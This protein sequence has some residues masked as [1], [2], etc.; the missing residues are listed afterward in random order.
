MAD[1]YENQAFFVKEW[2]NVLNRA[3]KGL[4]ERAAA[5]ALTNSNSVQMLKSG[6]DP[7]RIAALGSLWDKDK[8]ELGDMWRKQSAFL[9]GLAIRS[10]DNNQ[11]K[12]DDPEEEDIRY[13]NAKGV[14]TDINGAARPQSR[15]V[16]ASYFA[17][18]LESY[19]GAVALR[20]RVLGSGK[21]TY[22][23]RI[24]L[25]TC[26]K[27][28]PHVGDLKQ[29]EIEPASPPSMPNSVKLLQKTFFEQLTASQSLSD[30]GEQK[31]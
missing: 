5:A 23:E 26:F 7:A 12:L 3:R 13:R 22:S 10:F 9:V 31:W 28:P 16:S 14:L 6:T 29:W 27:L 11:S 25:K 17:G 19:G 18:D 30:E 2:R 1:P 15:T 4:S 24:R 20:D 21:I 8:T